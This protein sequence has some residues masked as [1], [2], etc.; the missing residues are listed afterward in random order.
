MIFRILGPDATNSVSLGE[1]RDDVREALGAFRE[2]RRTPD[3]D[4]SDQFEEGVI[5][6]YS[7]DG[8]LIMLEFTAPAE[9][10]IEAVQLLGTPLDDV[11][12]SLSNVG[13]EIRRDDMGAEVPKFGVGLFA[14]AGEIEG[15]ELGS[16]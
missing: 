5:A 15:V 10:E 8:T 2:F 12:V 3:S 7:P 4:V 13:V 16:D 11:E 9:V 1:T 6:T 14:P